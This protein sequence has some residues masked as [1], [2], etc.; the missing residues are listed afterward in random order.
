M[1]KKINLIFS[2]FVGIGGL[3]TL[4]LAIGYSIDNKS[5]HTGFNPYYM[6]L[7]FLFLVILGCLNLFLKQKRLAKFL[8]IVGL[9]GIALPML[10]DLTEIL[11]EYESWIIEGMPSV[12]NYRVPLM[13]I[14]G[15]IPLFYCLRICLKQFKKHNFC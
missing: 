14:Y 7:P 8:T 6:I 12:P 5:G 2:I 13:L 4:L 3:L 11:N 9:M 15:A 1:F 10:W